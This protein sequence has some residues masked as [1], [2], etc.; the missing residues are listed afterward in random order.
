[1]KKILTIICLLALVLMMTDTLFAGGQMNLSNLSAEYIRTWSRNASTDAADIVFYNPAGTTKM[2]DGFYI[3][4]VNQTYLGGTEITRRSDDAKF[5][6]KDPVWSIPGVFNV[7]KQDNWAAFLSANVY[8]GGG[9]GNY[10]E[11]L[12]SIDLLGPQLLMLNPATQALFP[13]AYVSDM[14]MKGAL[15]GIGTTVGGAY[16]INDF[17]SVSAGGRYIF[18]GGSSSE[19]SFT[20]SHPFAGDVITEDLEIEQSATGF[21]GIIGINNTPTRN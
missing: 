17:I 12:P 18:Y 14:E 9:A 6:S 19:M 16:A 20:V 21:G 1:M 5:D 8:F 3:N 15:Y 4:A 10:T 13:D 7:Y 11:G 2:D